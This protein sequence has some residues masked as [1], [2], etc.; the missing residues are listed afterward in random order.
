MKPH[1]RQPGVVLSVHVGQGVDNGFFFLYRAKEL[2]TLRPCSIAAGTRGPNG[3]RL[4][5][6][7]LRGV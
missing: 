3:E 2:S 7:L 4:L 5:I 1:P 6:P